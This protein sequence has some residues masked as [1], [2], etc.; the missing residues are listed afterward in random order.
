MSEAE[1]C[2][3]SEDGLTYTFSIRRNA[4]W[5]DGT[6]VTAHDFVWS[7]RRMLHPETASRYSYQLYYIKN[8]H[9][10]EEPLDPYPYF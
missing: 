10:A 9:P 6:S 5:S 3:I 1:D 7:W 2:S 4:H 8:P